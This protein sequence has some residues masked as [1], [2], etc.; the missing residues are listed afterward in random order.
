MSW[1]NDKTQVFTWLACNNNSLNSLFLGKLNFKV[2][3]LLT[4]NQIFKNRDN[5]QY[6]I[7]EI[8]SVLQSAQWMT[9]FTVLRL[10][11]NIYKWRCLK[12]CL[13]KSHRNI[14]R[15]CSLNCRAAKLLTKLSRARRALEW[16]HSG[17]LLVY[18][19]HHYCQWKDESSLN[20]RQTTS[21][22]Q[23]R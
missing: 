18:S 3:L 8:L 17:A 15:N 2:S 21:S 7:L 1:C 14:S 13:R 10:R 16:I 5:K 4:S 20:C 11:D 9:N 6:R 22:V 12:N 23:T 19:Y